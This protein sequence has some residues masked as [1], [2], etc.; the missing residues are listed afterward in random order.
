[1]LKCNK[2]YFFINFFRKKLLME[3]IAP[4]S[5]EEISYL[6]KNHFENLRKERLIQKLPVIDFK[7]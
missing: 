2:I 4:N 1:M 6:K 3:M 7:I 5:C